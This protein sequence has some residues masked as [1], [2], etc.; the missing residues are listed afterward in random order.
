VVFL[1]NAF[2]NRA[3]YIVRQFRPNIENACFTLFILK[4]SK[5]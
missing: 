3:L 4:N 2:G 1:E 5:F